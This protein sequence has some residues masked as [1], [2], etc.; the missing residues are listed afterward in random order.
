MDIKVIKTRKFLPPKD[1]LWGLLK[2]SIPELHE[3]SV[4]AIT[5]KV[6]SIGEGRCIPV[7][8][9]KDKD[10][11]IK[12]ESEFYLSR[13]AVPGRRIVH[14]ISNET[15]MSTAGIDESNA[16]DYYILWPKDPN[17]SAKKIWN[18][19]KKTYHLKNLGVVITDSHSIPL[20]RGLV[21]ISIAFWGFEHLRDYRGKKDIFGRVMSV[22]Q[23][24][25]PDS[26]AAFAVFLMGEGREQTPIVIFENLPTIKFVSQQKISK[27]RYTS[28][29]VPIE[30]DLF[31]P[32][33]KSVK[34]RKGRGV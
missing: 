20:R 9:V 30:E 18:F 27:N 10:E 4:V 34:W 24:N 33:L 25:I 7:D 1:D 26:I 31:R 23:S 6:V 14:T 3:N 11:L 15:L 17:K 32:F 28:W 21:G 2:E 19:L 12:R 29:K 22:S 13:E 8:E 5:S 16:N